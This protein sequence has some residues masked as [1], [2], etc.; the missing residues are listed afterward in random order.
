MGTPFLF[1]IRNFL[2]RITI[3]GH[4]WS[5]C[6][7]N[8]CMCTAILKLCTFQQQKTTCFYCDWKI[9]RVNELCVNVVNAPH[10]R[11]FSFHVFFLLKYESLIMMSLRHVTHMF[12]T[13]SDPLCPNLESHWTKRDNQGKKDGRMKR[14]GTSFMKHSEYRSLDLVNIFIQLWTRLHN[15]DILACLIKFAFLNEFKSREVAQF[16]HRH[17]SRSTLLEK[18][19]RH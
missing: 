18:N 13:W 3:S 16:Y 10:L 4:F 9:E 2:V 7:F 5:H 15:I 11:M 19:H 6:H 17:V 8:V 1:V 14:N 12:S